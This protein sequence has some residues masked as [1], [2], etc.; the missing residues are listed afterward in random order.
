MPFWLARR[1]DGQDE[2]AIQRFDPRFWTVNFPRP[3]MAS[4]VTFAPDLAVTLSD[5][6]YQ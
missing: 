3:M 1:R 4:V 2:D 6:E 5:H